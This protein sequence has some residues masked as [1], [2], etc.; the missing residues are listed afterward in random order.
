MLVGTDDWYLTAVSQLTRKLLI[1]AVHD[2]KKLL[3]YT[4]ISLET[5]LAKRVR[6]LMDN[7]YRQEVEK[8]AEQVCLRSIIQQYNMRNIEVPNALSSR[9][10]YE[11]N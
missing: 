3:E 1:M 7:E 8:L 9:V 11:K 4:R 10:E 6:E 2:Y 5:Y